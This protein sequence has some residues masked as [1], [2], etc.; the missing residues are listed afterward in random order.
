MKALEEEIQDKVERLEDRI[1]EARDEAS[2][3]E[4]EAD[5]M[6][7]EKNALEKSGIVIREKL[8][9]LDHRVVT[10]EAQAESWRIEAMKVKTAHAKGFREGV[11]KAAGAAK[12]FFGGPAHTYASEN[13]DVYRAQDE[14]VRLVAERIRAL[15]PASEGGEHADS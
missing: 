13:A 12:D 3:L 14:T 15:L 10:A 11:E 8:E 7:D 6:E 9:D 4:A 1:V 5:D 2:S